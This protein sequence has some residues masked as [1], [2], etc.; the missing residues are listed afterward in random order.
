MLHFAMLH[1]C[2]ILKHLGELV[3]ALIFLGWSAVATHDLVL[4]SIEVAGVGIDADTLALFLVVDRTAL[5]AYFLPD[6]LRFDLRTFGG[7]HICL[8]I[9]LK[10][11]KYSRFYFYKSLHHFS[12]HLSSLTLLTPHLILISK[13]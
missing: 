7:I 13:F 6:C 3:F 9:S 10:F 2:F 8:T 5:Y 1:L 11:N 12:F 4:V